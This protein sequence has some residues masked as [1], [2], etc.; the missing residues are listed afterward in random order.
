M[1]R[2]RTPGG[3]A[4]GLVINAG[5]SLVRG[6]AVNRFGGDGIVLGAGATNSR[7]EACYVGTNAAGT[8]AAGNGGA[9]IHVAA[10]RAVIGGGGAERRNVVSGND[11][12]ILFD[13][14]FQGV[15]LGLVSGNFVGT[16]A[17]G[18]HAVGNRTYGIEATTTLAV[19]VGGPNLAARNIISGNGASG[20]YGGVVVGNFIGTDVAGGTAVPNG[21][22][23]NA[24]YR[25]GVTLA[26]RITGNLISGNRG[27]GITLNGASA[28]AGNYVG[29][30]A[31]G[32]RRSAMTGTGSSSRATS[33]GRLR[34]GPDLRAA[35]DR[36][37]R[38][39]P[40]RHQRQWRQWRP[41]R[42]R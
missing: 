30:D 31:T 3:V 15:G 17:A 18:L 39:R 7:V 20:V 12:G 19:T 1:V 14:T 41:H 36:P 27:N 25:D 29:T 6:M 35:R 9:G 10:D 24:P 28:I 22:D 26:G 33:M 11:L 13:A 23:P 32:R 2:D 37:R 42:R 34:R 8:E 40:K 21:T 38:R 16:D 5:P 4:S